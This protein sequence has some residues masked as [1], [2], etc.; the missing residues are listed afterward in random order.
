M[1]GGRR[2]TGPRCNG[3]FLF[4]TPAIVFWR[5]ESKDSGTQFR[6]ETA[7]DLSRRESILTVNKQ[8]FGNRDCVWHRVALKPLIH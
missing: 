5:L 2:R 4:G 3:T 1:F 8:D 7:I 6:T